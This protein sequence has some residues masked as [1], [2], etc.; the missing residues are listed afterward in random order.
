MA[1]TPWGPAHTRIAARIDNSR[2]H[3]CAPPAQAGHR[4]L[5]PASSA[6]SCWSWACSALYKNQKSRRSRRR[7]HR[8]PNHHR[9]HAR[10][11][12]AP[13]LSSRADARPA[14]A[15]TKI[16]L[17]QRAR[18]RATKGAVTLVVAGHAHLELLLNWLVAYERHSS[19]WVIGCLDTSR[20]AAFLQERRIPCVFVPNQSGPL[21]PGLRLQERARSAAR[22]RN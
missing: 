8:Y 20:H 4:H 16:A 5:L 7:R 3:G 22:R 14:G 15:A 18:E 13:D 1:Q 9:L 11:R 6:V 10:H 19:N 21:V 17:L 12:P 2:P